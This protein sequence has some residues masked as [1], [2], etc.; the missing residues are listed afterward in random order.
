[1]RESPS[2]ES[3]ADAPAWSEAALQ[4]PHAEPD[5]AARV[6]AMF[7]AIAP[8]YE[9][10][11]RLATFGRDASWR[12][13]AVAGADPRPGE[14]VLDL[15]CGTGDM[16]REFATAEPRLRLIVGVDFSAKMLAAGSYP[17]TGPRRQLVRAD[18]LRLPLADE[19]VDIVSCAFGVRNFQ[20]LAAGL[21]EMARVVRPGGRVVILEFATPENPVIRWAHR[22][23]C[24]AVLPRLGALIARDRSGAYKYLPRSIETFETR[25]SL[26][27]RLA[28]AE[29]V[30]LSATSMNLGG[31][32]LYRGVKA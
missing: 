24:E 9:K 20:D 13:R 25:S 19:S 30:D 8:T 31:V 17:A 16:V 12:K 14:I 5:K 22:I 26:M 21:I 6:E 2:I 27:R 29:F 32:V 18:G 11:N 7:D 1:M 23:Y 28:E 15:C 4:A 10:V 3:L